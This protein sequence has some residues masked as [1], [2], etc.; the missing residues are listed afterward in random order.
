MPIH[1]ETA[2]GFEADACCSSASPSRGCP[3]NLRIHSQHGGTRSLL[4]QFSAIQP[5][6]SSPLRTLCCGPAAAGPTARGLL[7]ERKH[8]NR[9]SYEELKW[10]NKWLRLKRSKQPGVPAAGHSCKASRCWVAELKQQGSPGKPRHTRDQRVTTKAALLCGAAPART[11]PFLESE[12]GT[13]NDSSWTSLAWTDNAVL[14]TEISSLIGLSR[15][16]H[17]QL[18]KGRSAAELLGAE[19]HSASVGAH[20]HFHSQAWK[21][22]S[23]SPPLPPRCHLKSIWPNYYYPRC[24]NSALCQCE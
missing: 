18:H 4:L 2:A 16:Q 9:V 12:T 22:P 7:P 6:S 10:G 11:A 8:A 24:V 21:C 1:S 5:N 17:E 14:T 3:G 23:I 20:R 15:E 19:E 13:C